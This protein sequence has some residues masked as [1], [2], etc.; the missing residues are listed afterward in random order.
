MWQAAFLSLTD[1][2]TVALDYA[3]LAQDKEATIFELELGKASLGAE[4]AWVSQW[5]QEQERLLPPWTF[6]EVVQPPTRREDG[7]TVV[8]IKPTV[9]QNVRTVEEVSGARKEKFERT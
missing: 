1:D 5:P 7:L 2:P 9:F 3:R 4:V 6:L 8:K